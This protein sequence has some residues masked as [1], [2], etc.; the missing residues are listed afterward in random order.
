MRL[1]ISCLAVVFV[2][3]VSAGADELTIVSKTTSDKNPQPDTM[4]S[5][6][7]TEH[8]RMAQPTGMDVMLDYKTGQI[9]M[10]DNKK[11]QYSVVT[12]ED[13]QALQ[14][15]LQDAMNSPEMKKAQEQMKNLPP[16]VQKKMEAMMGGGAAS[17]DVQKTGTSRKIAGYNC[18]NWTMTMGSISRTEQCLTTELQF[19]AEAWNTYRDFAQSMLQ[20]LGSMAGPM[21]KGMGQIAEKMKEMKGFPLASATVVSVMGHSTTTTSEVTDIKKGPI[22]ASA[23]EIPAGYTKVDNPM[24]AGAARSK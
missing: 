19:P 2:A 11:K 1:S 5:Y 4:T 16:E 22:P 3:S 20:S 12:K 9:T 6:L 17:V 7:G 10:I 13:M 15:R 14:A 8:L 24:L 18:D 21:A 23:W